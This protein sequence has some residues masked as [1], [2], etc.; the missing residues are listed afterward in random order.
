MRRFDVAAKRGGFTGLT[1]VQKL[2]KESKE[3]E[4]RLI[5][6]KERMSNNGGRE[7]PSGGKWQSART[8]RGYL[9]GYSKTVLFKHRER[10]EH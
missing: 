8:D 6:L 5:L 9:S 3:M 7:I 4:M 10:T 2:E 1:E